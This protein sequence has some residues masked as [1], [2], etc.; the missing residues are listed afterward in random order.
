MTGGIEENQ[1]RGGKGISEINEKIV[2]F[3]PMTQ[4]NIEHFSRNPIKQTPLRHSARSL[5]LASWVTAND[6]ADTSG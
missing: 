6:C 1:Q 4:P 3:P 2:F 5:D